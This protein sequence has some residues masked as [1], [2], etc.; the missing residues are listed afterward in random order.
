MFLA[1][2]LMISGH[3]PT[4]LCV[5][6]LAGVS[7]TSWAEA[8]STTEEESRL[9]DCFPSVNSTLRTILLGKSIGLAKAAVDPIALHFQL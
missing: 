5:L 8:S 4:G 1:S 6:S 2:A 3:C 7:S 9:L